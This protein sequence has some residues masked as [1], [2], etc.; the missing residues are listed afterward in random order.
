MNF[1]LAFRR[2]QAM[3]LSAW[4]F[5]VALAFGFGLVCW[6][7]IFIAINGPTVRAA[8]ESQR[9]EEIKQEDQEHCTK[10]G[11]PPATEAFGTCQNEL[12]LIRR[13]HDERLHRDLQFP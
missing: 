3:S 11:M 7:L 8:I 4:A 10:L 1:D 5:C 2:N 13:R 12:V 9:I 6:L